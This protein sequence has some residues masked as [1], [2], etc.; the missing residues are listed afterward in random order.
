MLVIG[1][2]RVGLA[3]VGGPRVTN[4][5]NCARSPRIVSGDTPLVI[6]WYKLILT[7]SMPKLNPGRGSRTNPT[8]V[9]CDVSGTKLGLPPNVAGNCVRQSFELSVTGQRTGWDRPGCVT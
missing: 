8:L 7:Q 5:R 9:C 2:G 1:P 6:V 3:A 4:L